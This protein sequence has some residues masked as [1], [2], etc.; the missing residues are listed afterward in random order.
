[1]RTN[2][3][4]SLAS[5]CRSFDLATHRRKMVYVLHSELIDHVKQGRDRYVVKCNREINDLRHY[6]KLQCFTFDVRFN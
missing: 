5:A 3:P 2:L 6:L 4:S 1:M